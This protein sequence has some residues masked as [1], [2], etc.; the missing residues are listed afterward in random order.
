LLLHSW[1]G[2]NDVVTAL[3]DRLA[4]DG[5]VVVAPDLFDGVVVD[6]IEAAEANLGEVEAGYQEIYAKVQRA[7]D[8]LLTGDGS[9]KAVVIGFSFGAA[10]GNWL[11]SERDDLAGVVNF[12][13]GVG[14]DVPDGSEAE[15]W[16]WVTSE[17]SPAYL[18]HFAEEDPYE[19]Q[20]PAGV[21]GFDT[22]LRAS[23]PLSAAYLY[24][25]VKHWFFEADRPEFNRD[26]AELAYERTVQFLTDTL[27]PTDH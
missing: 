5:F 13:G 4:G 24:P 15:P 8:S 27:H 25:G 2:L 26:A 18:A 7:L 10:Y 23:N 3:A 9:S 22:R 16:Q 1:W 11:A 17:T 6:T 14:F 12:Y 21:E 20:D 19:D